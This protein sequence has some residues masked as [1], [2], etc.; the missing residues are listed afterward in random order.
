[1]ASNSISPIEHFELNQ[2]FVTNGDPTVTYVTRDADVEV[3]IVELIMTRQKIIGLSGPSKS[4]KTVMIRRIVNETLRWQLIE[5]TGNDI[6]S[7]IDFWNIISA[8]LG[9][10][11]ET[12]QE[13]R[14]DTE[15]AAGISGG[16]DAVVV[17]S[18]VSSSVGTSSGNSTSTT[19]SFDIRASVRAALKDRTICILIDDFHYAPAPVRTQLA[20]TLKDLSFRGTSIVLIAVPHK[21]LDV[22]QAEHEL[23]GRVVRKRVAHWTPLELA[24]IPMQGFKALNARDDKAA[25]ST[26]VVNQSF[27]S[28]LLVQEL[29]AGVCRLNQLDK[30][31]SVQLMLSP[32][33][34]WE[35][36]FTNFASENVNHPLAQSL[37]AGPQERRRRNLRPLKDLDVEVDKYSAVLLGLQRCLPN[38]RM[39]LTELTDAVGSILQEK[40]TLQQVRNVCTTMQDIGNRQR[41]DGDP[42]V[43]FQ[44]EVR[45]ETFTIVDPYLAYFLAWGLQSLDLPVLINLDRKF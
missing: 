15:Y 3:D 28:P 38:I 26:A 37:R 8:A 11:S 24:R 4:G 30:T 44:N 23:I 2:V 36:Y 6:N 41:Q 34:S 22:V 12:R 33:I 45:P 20:R 35:S 21:V 5:I 31:A 32:P 42:A 13:G 9:I 17:K 19:K 18:E 27:G 39:T 40:M 7:D 14:H 25:I 16:L 29:C 10:N 43:E 1:M